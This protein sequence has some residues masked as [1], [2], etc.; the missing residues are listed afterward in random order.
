VVR[1]GRLFQP[2]GLERHQR[3]GGAYRFVHTPAH[4]GVDHQRKAGS[5]MVTHRPHTLHVLVKVWT[6]HLHLDGPEPSLQ[7]LV[8]LA[9]Q[10][11]DREIE[12]DAAW[13]AG[14]LWIEAAEHTPKRRVLTTRAKIPA[15]DVDGGDGEALRAASPAVVQRPPHG[16]PELLDAVGV[17]SREER[18]DVVRD[19]GVNGTA[20]GTYGVGVAHTFRALGVAH[21][22]G[23]QLERG[24]RPVRA[25]GQR[26]RQGNTVVI[27]AHVTDQHAGA[28]TSQ[29]GTSIRRSLPVCMS[30]SSSSRS[31]L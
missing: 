2:D 11:V 13:V 23:D 4:V 17:L 30:C 14:H 22:D 29:Y 3:A 28:W 19:E 26:D 1:D 25:V 18:S 15:R 9:E 16:L 21:A 12:A 24:D 5:E 31:A 7:V 8:R 6:S 10:G 27:G 20:A